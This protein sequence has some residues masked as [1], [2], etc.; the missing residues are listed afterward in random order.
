ME[1]AGFA[2]VGMIVALFTM[3][4]SSSSVD[5]DFLNLTLRKMKVFSNVLVVRISTK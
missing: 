1:Y 4:S 5:M 3:S 2:T